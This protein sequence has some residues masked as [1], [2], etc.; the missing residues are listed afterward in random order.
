MSEYPISIEGLKKIPVPK[1]IPA[2]FVIWSEVYEEKDGVTETIYK[3]FDCKRGVIRFKDT[4]ANTVIQAAIDALTGGGKIFIKAGTYTLSSTISLVSNIGIIGEGITATKLKV[5]DNANLTSLFYLDGLENV[6]LAHF[7]INGNKAN[8][9]DGVGIWLQ[10]CKH[11]CL[12]HLYI[13][14][15]YK[16]CITDRA[17][18]TGVVAPQEIGNLYNHLKLSGAGF[19]LPNFDGYGSTHGRIINSIIENSTGPGIHL[20][21]RAGVADALGWVVANN[22][23]RENQR[24]GLIIGGG[25]NCLVYGN[26]VYDNDNLDTSTYDNIKDHDSAFGV[27]IANTCWFNLHA[28][29]Y[30]I[31][32]TSLSENNIVVRNNLDTG[33]TPKQQVGVI[34]DEGTDNVIKGN[35]GYVT[36]NSGTATFSGDGTTTDFLIGAHGLAE[37]PTDRT[38]IYAEVTPA[39]DDAITASPCEA[40]ASDEDTDGAYESIRVKFAS[41]PAAGTDNVV[42]RWKAELKT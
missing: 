38:R 15:T 8:Q 20:R 17:D 36:E 7:E 31:H 19:N 1:I 26:V 5:E 2:N 24:E 40:Y 21:G 13:H 28:G 35:I 4:D 3:A 33:L 39:S 12:E 32:L 37:N 29:A 9:N 27:Y 14:D 42:V 18:A 25:L 11:C 22:Q 41:A 30:L 10:N 16:Y 34:L 23:I 6:Y